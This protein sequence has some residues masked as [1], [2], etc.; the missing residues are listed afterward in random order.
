MWYVFLPILWPVIAALDAVVLVPLPALL[1]LK[2]KPGMAFAACMI[3]LALLVIDHL[4][5][6]DGITYPFRLLGVPTETLPV[7][8]VILVGTGA[9]AA[10][11]WLGRPRV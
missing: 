4:V 3:M 6:F 8:I 11:E 10:K 9:I 7:S 2:Q 1:I 5:N